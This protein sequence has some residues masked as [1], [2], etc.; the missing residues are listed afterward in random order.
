MATRE[1]DSI[2]FARWIIPVLPAGKRLEDH[3]LVIQDGR[4][5]DIL[6]AAKAR[7]RWTTEHPVD[8][9]GHALIPG[10]VN[11]HTHAAMNLMR[12]LADDLPLM[13]WLQEHIWPAET[14]HMSSQFVIDGVGLSA[15]EMI[16][17]GTTCFNDM[18]FFPDATAQ[19]AAAAGMRCSVGMIVL[20]FPTV[21]AGNAHE[22]I[23]KG[24]AIRDR[25]RDHP[26]IDTMFAPHA[27]YTVSDEPLR[28]L[29][30]LADEMD[31]RVHMHVHETAFEV[32]TAVKDSGRRPLARLQELGLVNPNLLAV[33]MT[34]LDEA[35]I[36]LCAEHGVSVIHCPESNMKLASGICPTAALLAAGVNVALGTDGAASNNDVD[37]FGEMRSAALL[38]KVGSGD[39]AALPAAAVLQMATLNGAR[40]LGLEDDIGSLETGKSADLCAINLDTPETRPV[41]DPISQIVYAAGREQVTD[42]WVAGKQLMASRQLKTLDSDR[43]A[44]TAEDWRTRLAG[45]H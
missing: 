10:L 1:A 17:G 3:A 18:Y 22:Y 29:R 40:A 12:G 11:A 44:R 34:Q 38:G 9:P 23:D 16:R 25:Y 6:P 42:V 24:L 7:Q 14:E 2:L 39:A 27:P 19:T 33:H 20:D 36:A 30:M 31:L 26:L 4:I 37:M 35:E 8:L 15:A 43:L 5:A 41:Y 28:K 13:I 32:D 45:K 21:W